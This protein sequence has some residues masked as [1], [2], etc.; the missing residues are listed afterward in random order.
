MNYKSRRE[1]Y[2]IESEERAK[3]KLITYKIEEKF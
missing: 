2:A 1:K 3:R